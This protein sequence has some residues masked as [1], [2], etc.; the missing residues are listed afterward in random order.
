MGARFRAEYLLLSLARML[1][2][3]EK[4]SLEEISEIAEVPIDFVESV[5]S[6]LGVTS[7]ELR[8]EDLPLVLVRAWRAGFSLLDMALNAGWSTLEELVGVL[9]DEYGFTRRRNVRIKLAGK[10]YEIDLLAWRGNLLLCIDCKR[11]VRVR[12]S[13]LKLAALSQKER[14]RAVAKLIENGGAPCLSCATEVE[15]FPLVVS[16]HQSAIAA[17]EGVLVTSIYGLAS[18]LNDVS[19]FMLADA[20]AEPFRATCAT[21]R[22]KQI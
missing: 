4:I 3:R 9:L 6:S 20:G 22:K 21:Y 8:R 10:R 14:C 18:I 15:I 13:A 11:W 2:A 19:A 12:A 16:L 5:L 17:Y 1:S 7:R